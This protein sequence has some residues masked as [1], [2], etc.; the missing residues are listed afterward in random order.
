[1]KPKLTNS[2][3]Y[4]KNFP[5][6]NHYFSQ[7]ILIVFHGLKLGLDK[8]ILIS[9]IFK[10]AFDAFD[11]FD[12]R[13]IDIQVLWNGVEEEAIE[14]F[15]VDHAFI[16]QS[17]D[18]FRTRLITRYQNH[19]L[20]KPILFADFLNLNFNKHTLKI[21]IWNDRSQVF[22]LKNVFQT[23]SKTLN[24]TLDLTLM[25][26]KNVKAN[27]YLNIDLLRN[28]SI[29][30]SYEFCHN[31]P[32]TGVSV[33]PP[34]HI[35]E[36]IT[37]F[38]P[39]KSFTL[40]DLFLTT[41]TEKCFV[42]L[43]ISNLLISLVLLMKSPLLRRDIAKVIFEV[44]G[45]FYGYSLTFQSRL[46]GLILAFGVLGLLARTNYQA[47]YF[48]ALTLN[49]FDVH[50]SSWQEIEDGDY[51]II[52]PHLGLDSNILLQSLPSSLKTEIVPKAGQEVLE[53]IDQLPYNAG[54]F[55][56]KYKVYFHLKQGLIDPHTHVVPETILNEYRCLFFQKN[57]PLKEVF[58]RHIKTLIETGFIEKWLS[59]NIKTAKLEMNKEPN[60][61]EVRHILNA[62]LLVGSGL[63]AAF[64]VFLMEVLYFKCFHIFVYVFCRSNG[65]KSV[66]KIKVKPR[67][68]P[69]QNRWS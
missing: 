15:E 45:V 12:P 66:K 30:C 6:I 5:N 35:V 60:Q 26:L 42:L 41:F 54:V 65:T 31:K 50:P 14:L 63:G 19:T 64:V 11:I 56:D 17:F 37:V 51:K 52:I 59:S 8:E 62:F 46:D 24:F 7:R 43:E 25:E 36:L 44:H 57:H 48:K 40:D 1:M 13:I 69:L 4:L 33:L 18:D 22:V 10:S 32:F 23:L 67:N 53:D 9:K 2:R 21:A 39:R 61:I 49:L 29:D 3:T 58:N 55:I 27:P 34:Y 68:V 28:R 38:P 47:A 20:S 16:G